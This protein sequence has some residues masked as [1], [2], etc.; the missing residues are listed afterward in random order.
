LFRAS[1]PGTLIAWPQALAANVMTVLV[2]AVAAIAVRS[3][4]HPRPTSDAVL[5]ALLFVV[6]GVLAV[7]VF[8]S[9]RKNRS[10]PGTYTRV[11]MAVMAAM[12]VAIAL[13]ALVFLLILVG[14][15]VGVK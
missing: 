3:S 4:V 11:F 13:G 10:P 12:T 8:A 1:R 7:I 2:V 5:T 6:F 14:F 15:A 9:V